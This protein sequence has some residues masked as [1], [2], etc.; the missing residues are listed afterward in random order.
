MP[1]RREIDPDEE[2]VTN[3][4]R[5]GCKAVMVAH[6][7][8][9]AGRFRALLKGRHGA[10]LVSVRIGAPGEFTPLMDLARKG[11]AKDAPTPQ[12]ADDGLDYD[13]Y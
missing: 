5:L 1:K 9:E 8:A 10:G 4:L 2:A 13:G 3:A 7:E 12:P 6:D 11:G